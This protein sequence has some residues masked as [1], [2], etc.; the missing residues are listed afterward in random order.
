M[1]GTL[2]VALT[3]ASLLA[4]P[5][6][7]ARSEPRSFYFDMGTADSPLEA[8]YTRVTA[9]TVYDKDRGF[10]WD[11]PAQEAFD[12]EI[13]V[14]D[15]FRA[16]HPNFARPVDFPVL[17]DGI[18]DK[19]PLGF[20]VDVPPGRYWVSVIVGRYGRKCHD[21]RVTLNGNLVAEN[22]DAWGDVWG[23]QG[24]TPT[25]S[26]AVVTEPKDGQFAFAFDYVKPEPDRWKEYTTKRPEDGRLWYLGPNRNA[27][28]AIRIRPHARAD[29][30]LSNPLFRF[31][32]VIDLGGESFP[33]PMRTAVK[34]FNQGRLNDA[35]E[36]LCSW[37]PDKHEVGYLTSKGVLH[38]WLVGDMRLDDQARELELLSQSIATWGTLDTTLR[39]IRPD[40]VAGVA[41][42]IESARRYRQALI[43]LHMYGYAWAKEMTGLNKYHRYW[44][45]YDLCG[46]FTPDDPL[47][48][49]SHLVRGRVAYW[50]GREGGWKHCY[51]LAKKHFAVLKEAFPDNRLVR[52]YSGEKVPTRKDYAI[53]A[54]GA[55]EWARLQHEAF[56]R[57][58]DVI[59][60][61]VEH[62]Q[63]D[64]GE[65]G[66]GWGDDVEI[67]RT[68]APAVLAVD[69]PVALRGLRGITE[70]VWN[71]G[72]I[73]NGYSRK[74]G[75]VEHAAE[76]VSDTQ[77]LM[78]AVDYGNPLYVERC[79]ATM[80][81]MRDVWTAVNDHGHRH[82]KSHYYSATEVDASG[83]RAADVALNGRAAKPGIWVLWYNRHPA[84]E[85]VLG[86]WCRAW[87]EDA[88]R[89]DNG[90]PAGFVPGS[91][92]FEDD[93]IG[94]FADAWWQTRGYFSDFESVGYTD[95][96][97]HNMLAKF[98]ITEDELLGRQDE[99]A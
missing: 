34:A 11:R 23:S 86:Q 67:L 4:G 65:L 30:H 42:R 55:P 79:M 93:R 8:G 84:V 83:T 63:A 19:R 46:P 33:P 22:I 95:E 17:R 53:D 60:Y 59:H 61:W 2:L 24:G 99:N 45:A 66:G 71:S 20:R 97:Y 16:T 54:R 27:I 25:K 6:D 14:P 10:G 85:E 29:T 39:S 81:C 80:A 47:Y 36:A 43:Y 35:A 72:Q 21:M 69:D 13:D 18:E 82:F 52:M 75:D 76:P 44:A 77:P 5:A 62:R 94:G 68:W 7:P 51:D 12:D 87:V 88:F 32:G 91:V 57:Y 9:K 89:T 74:V 90:K 26:V 70:G 40:F 31:H 58:M 1:L 37:D 41:A 49:K 98:A 92:R 3:G 48:Y 38:D 56:A 28:V 15:K 50:N 78:M 64:N 96:L 73:E